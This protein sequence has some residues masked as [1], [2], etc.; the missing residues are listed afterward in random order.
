VGALVVWDHVTSQWTP[1]S[2][3]V[4]PVVPGVW[5]D[6]TNTGYKV[7]LDSLTVTAG[8]TAQSNHIYENLYIQGRLDMTNKTNVTVRNCFIEVADYFGIDAGGATN[9]LVED[10]TITI[11]SNQA[12]C[13][14]LDTGSGGNMYRRLNM[15][16]AQDGMKL[17][18][19][20]TLRD[21]WI[22][23]LTPY[24]PIADTHNDGVQG[25]GSSNVSIIHNRIEMG[26][27]ATSAIGFFAGQVGISDGF[28]LDSNKL[29][30]GGYIVY[31]PGAGSTNMKIRNNV[32]GRNYGYGPVTDYADGVGNEWLNNTYEDNGDP[33]SQWG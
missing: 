15:S 12:N 18:S 21:S 22:H 28:I 11:T 8:F 19:G 13:C 23:D 29:S 9:C 14:I 17:G 3:T 27:N 7:S 1:L 32:F 25:T 6:A 33:V 24:D 5:P 16:G 26:E 31:L 10:T 20:S 4:A 2:T 30:G